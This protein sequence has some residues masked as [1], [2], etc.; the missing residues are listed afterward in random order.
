MVKTAVL[1]SGGGVNLQSLIDARV[2][3]EI[4]ECNLAAVIS[5]NPDAYAL[6]R[7]EMATIPT[8]I[9]ERELFPNLATFGLALLDK[10]RDL[11]IGLVVLAGFDCQLTQPIFDRYGGRIIDTYPALMPAFVEDYLE[12]I[13]IPSA[14]LRA[15]V[16]IS[17]ATA[18]F[19]NEGKRN[20][21]IITQKAVAVRQDDDS[22]T[23][24][25]R[26]LEE[27]ETYVLPRAVDLFCRGKLVVEN[28]VVNITEHP[29]L[30]D[31]K[32]TK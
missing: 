2:F 26:I 19:A 24:S 17:G 3:G 1:V 28:G 18:F 15:G 10:L 9:V 21:P 13:D 31:D 23:L 29:I 11:D 8:Y 5:S 22:V 32:T 30:T 20:G 4:Q 14:Q 25:R 6:E 27:G 16:K 7:A 12:D